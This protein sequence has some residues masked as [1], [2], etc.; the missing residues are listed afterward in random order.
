MQVTETETNGLKREFKIVLPAS[1]I[2]AQVESR[3]K[4]LSTSIKMPGFRPGKVPMTMMKKRYG[5]SVMGEVLE[6][7]VQDSSQQAIE[8]RGL[9]P[10]LLPK[11]EITEFAEG[12]GLEY[13]M[14]VEILPEIQAMDFAK[15]QLDRPKAEVTDADVEKGIERLTSQLRRTRKVEEERPAAAGDTVVIDF[16][17][18]L[19]GVP[20]EG[21][22]A[23]GHSLELGSNSF[24]PGFE[25]QVVGMKAGET[26]EI[27]VK[28]P[29]D[30]GAENLKGREATF[31]VTAH[32]LR[33]S[34]AAPMDDAFVKETFG[35]EG[36][37]ALRTTVRDRIEKDFAGAS[38]FRVKRVLLDK[39]AENHDF[40]VPEGMVE[41]EFEAI[42]KQVTD[43][44][45]RGEEDPDQAGKTEDEQKADYRN[46]AERRVR[47]GLLLSEVGRQ[48]NIQVT[49]DELKRA[50][51]EEARRY[52]GQER[53]VFEYYNKNP[54]AMDS[55]RAPLFEEKVVDFILEMAKVTDT[56]VSSEELF[57]EPA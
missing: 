7:V 36:V 12:K 50:V 33:E 34:D 44:K 47:L 2:D 6:K 13:T 18:K 53:Q 55:L 22:A 48:N 45:A 29:D 24:I 39:L 21:G 31:E 8:E 35:L 17:G 43:A 27:T 5:A 3:L 54:E 38:R 1:A 9:R 41:R 19:D 25:D 28:F 56:P 37:D 4:Q 40:A 42:W 57:K 15:L 32:E 20:F 14:S 16:L 10:A 26:R 11:V 46:I 30:Y 51:F 49:D 52:P 23:Q